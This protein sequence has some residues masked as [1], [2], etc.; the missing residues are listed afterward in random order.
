MATI[1]GYN[2]GFKLCTPPNASVW[3]IIDRFR[4]EDNLI[5]VSL[6]QAAKGNEG[7]DAKRK[8]KSDQTKKREELKQIVNNYENVGFSIYME[9]MIAYFDAD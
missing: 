4:E 3:A 8:R 6:G 9:N 7:P 5:K 2:H 1:E